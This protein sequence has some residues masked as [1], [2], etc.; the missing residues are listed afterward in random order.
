MPDRRVCRI[1]FVLSGGLRSRGRDASTRP[2]LG[3]RCR[4]GDPPDVASGTRNDGSLRRARTRSERIE[5]SVDGRS[6]ACRTPVQDV[7]VD[8]RGRDV[9]VAEELLDGADIA[10]IFEQMGGERVPEGVAGSPFPD[11]RVPHRSADGPLHDGLV[12]MMTASLTRRCLMVGSR[13]GENPLPGPFAASRRR[14]SRQGVGKLRPSLRPVRGRFGVG[15]ASG[16][17]G[18]ITSVPECR[19][20]S[21]RGPSFPSRAGRR[22]DAARNP[23]PSRG[24]DSTRAAAVPIRR[25]VRP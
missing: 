15:H 13:G 25:A 8:H 14:L 4:T 3:I 20:E 6:H 7:R 24:V 2:R 18:P 22:S 23:R 17:D 19:E 9:F 12:E 5:E 16:R 21:R 1:L 11:S 10:S